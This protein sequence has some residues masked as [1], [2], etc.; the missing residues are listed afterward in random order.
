VNNALSRTWQRYRS[1][2][3]MKREAATF[4]VALVFSL[5]ILPLAI[6]GAGQIFLGD[7]QRSYI[8]PLSADAAGNGGPVDL[9]VDF[10]HGIFAGSPGHWLVLLGPYILLWAY[11]LGRRLV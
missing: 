5:T 4:G 9:L 6:W 10:V 8:D 2:P 7:Y 3:V 1:L 11:R